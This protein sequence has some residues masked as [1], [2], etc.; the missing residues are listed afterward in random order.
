MA[1]VFSLLPWHL[2]NNCI[3]VFTQRA[4]A[5]LHWVIPIETGIDTKHHS[6]LKRPALLQDRSFKDE[7]ISIL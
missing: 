3:G 5:Q 7:S 1:N 6:E 4:P 2:E